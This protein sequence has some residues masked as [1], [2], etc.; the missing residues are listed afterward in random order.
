ML[1]H[2]LWFA[3]LKFGTARKN[4][5][6][7]FFPD[8]EALYGASEIEYMATG[9]LDG[10]Q[11]SALCCKSLDEADRIL[12]RCGKSAV[13]VV[14]RQDSNYP[15]RLKNI[16]GAPIVLYYKG[17]FPDFDSE[18]AVAVVGSRSHT[19]YGQMAAERLA[20]EIAEGGGYIV[21]GMARGIDAAA[22]RGALRAGKPTTAVLGCGPDIIY[23]KENARLYEDILYNGCIMSEYPPGSEPL[24]FHF[25]E[26][27]RIVSGLSLGVLVVEAGRKS[28]ALITANLA[29]D[30]GRDVFAVPGNIDAPGSEGTNGLI[31]TGAKL[32][33]SGREVLSEYAGLFPEK[34]NDSTRAEDILD[35]KAN[36]SNSLTKDFTELQLKIIVSIAKKPLHIDEIIE[37][38]GLTAPEAL[39]EL[40]VLEIEGA[41]AQLPGKRFSAVSAV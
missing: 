11:I 15:E 39:A 10:R 22:H 17:R 16:D 38:C 23:P 40:T 12:E 7:D 8:V 18:A 34:L 3:S 37:T 41:V 19:A 31:K 20:Y 27:N 28:G 1:R 2:W 30:Q 29:A 32:V 4:E 33:T 9:I 21:S 13:S 24:T 5:L 14:T 26:R 25:P 36:S 6:L 35:S